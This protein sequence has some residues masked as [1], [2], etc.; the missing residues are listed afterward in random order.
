MKKV[1]ILGSTGMA[2]HVIYRYFEELGIYE[3]YNLSHSYKLNENTKILD[4]RKLDVFEKFLDEIKFD[5]IVNCIGL[6]NDFAERSPKDAIL[7]NSYLPKFLEEKYLDSNT[8]IIHLSTD[9]VFSG[10]QG[11][12]SENSFKDGN[13]IYALT[14]S[15]G[16]IDNNKDLTIR[17]SI[18]GPDINKNGIGL[19]NWFMKQSG[20]IKGYKNV[21]WTGIT[22]IEL[23]KA[24]QEFIN[25]NITGI[26]HLIPKEKI[27]KYELLILLK[28]T[29]GKSE[30]NIYEDNQIISDKS[31]LNTR[32]DFNY[33]VHEY[34]EMLKHMKTWIEANKKNY[35]HYIYT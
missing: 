9:C 26:Y 32:T 15:I 17:T 31:L 20:N 24:I 18:I 13:T 10:K 4:V 23:A 35:D 22:T 14:K 27:S 2:G 16:E 5:I 12:Y 33:M 8:K 34:T 25:Q 6:L 7:V 28:S 21:I 3:L 11:S 29:F 1:L 19:F 30:I